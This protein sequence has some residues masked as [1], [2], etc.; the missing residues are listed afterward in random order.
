MRGVDIVLTRRSDISNAAQEGIEASGWSFTVLAE[1]N[2]IH[3]RRDGSR[4]QN[5]VPVG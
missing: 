5:P 3:A 1:N 4:N 2:P